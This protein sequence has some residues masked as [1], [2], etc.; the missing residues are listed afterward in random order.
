[1]KRLVVQNPA[2]E[3]NIPD[4]LQKKDEYDERDKTD[5]NEQ[6]IL[7]MWQGGVSLLRLYS[8]PVA[9]RQ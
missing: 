3:M 6:D 5:R 2:R 8:G 4:S 9:I 7:C 1:M